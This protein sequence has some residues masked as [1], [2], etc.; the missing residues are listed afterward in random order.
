MADIM[1]CFL[2]Q[3]KEKREAAKT[4]VAQSAGNMKFWAHRGLSFAYPENTLEAFEAAAQLTGLTGIELDVQLTRDGAVVVFHD[5]NVSR[6]TDGTKNVQEYTLTELKALHIQADGGAVT[7]IPT[8]EEVLTLLAPYC[9]RNGLQINIELKTS[10]ARYEGIEAKTIELVRQHGLEQYIV[11]S[12]FLAESIGIVKELD[13]TAK[14]GMLAYSLAD[15][16]KGAGQVHADALHPCTAGMDC[17]VPEDMKELPVRAWNGDEP[18][19]C[20]KQQ[21]ALKEKH[22]EKY[23]MFGVTEL[24]TNVAEAYV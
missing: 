1:E 12:S 15:C 23:A 22:L 14:T 9:R 24:F 6:V 13:R 3:A 20:N 17:I 4:V 8:L 2:A 7:T 16:I 19:Y 5:E 10:I 21:K 11:Y 18:I